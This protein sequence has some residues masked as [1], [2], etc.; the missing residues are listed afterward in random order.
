MN[1]SYWEHKTWIS[2][3]DFT[4]VGSGIVGLNCALRLRERFPSARIVVLEKGVWPQ[5][6]STKNAGFACFGSISEILSDLEHHSEEDVLQ[7]AQNRWD[8]IQWLRAYLGDES[9]G[10]QNFGG[11]ELFLEEQAES[12]AYCLENLNR[13]N[14]LLA[15]VYKAPAFKRHP[16]MFRFNK[17]VPHY[18]TN[19]F[20]GQLDTGRMMAS[21][22]LKAQKKHIHV[23]NANAV[24]EYSE[25]T[26]G[27]AVKTDMF[28]F[29]TKKLCIATNGFAAQLADVPVKPARAQVLITKPIQNL[30]IKGT[31]HLEQGY[32][33]FRNVDRRILLGGG[34]NLDFDTEETTEP[35]LTEVVQ[36]KLETLLAEVILHN[37]PFEIERRWSGIMGVGTEKKPIIKQVAERVYC[38]VR[39]GGMGIAIG[40]FVGRELADLSAN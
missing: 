12:Y 24:R 15:P 20:E 1:L 28:E 17:V 34:R 30:G 33:Y 29:N 39:L 40:S 18:I 19:T 9:I 5:G 37:S 4:V 31:F 25:C 27:V 35:G 22:L 21:L 14:D 38:G 8:G 26:N 7:L 3:I 11:H 36:N 6:A 16:N 32:Y 23:L 10:F 2:G 13:I